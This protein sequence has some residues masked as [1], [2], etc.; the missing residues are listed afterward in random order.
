MKY[1]SNSWNI[2]KE[3]NNTWDLCHSVSLSLF[4]IQHRN[5]HANKF[6]L[7]WLTDDNK[8]YCHWNIS[9]ISRDRHH[10]NASLLQLLYSIIYTKA[11]LIYDALHHLAFF[12]QHHASSRSHFILL[13]L[14]HGVVIKTHFSYLLHILSPYTFCPPCVFV[15]RV[16]LQY[17]ELF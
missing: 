5:W 7:L 15:D 4:A 2:S 11:L 1:N 9:I 12:A 8:N 3:F 13:R 6:N 10:L 17:V 16:E 14:C